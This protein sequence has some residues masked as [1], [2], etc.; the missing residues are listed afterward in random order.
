MIIALAHFAE[1]P[2]ENPYVWSL[3]SALR[4]QGHDVRPLPASALFLLR[5][6]SARAASTI[7]FQWFETQVGADSWIKMALKSVVF[8]AQLG[9]CK[10]LGK[11]LVWTVH[12]ATSHELLF[13]RLEHWVVRRIAA[14]AD[15][16]IF[17]CEAIRKDLSRYLGINDQEKISIVEHGNYFGIYRD[18]ISRDAA[19]SKFRL[20]ESDMVILFLGNIRPYKGLDDLIVAFNDVRRPGIK[21]L[22]AGKPLN[23]SVRQ[24][25]ENLCGNNPDI[26]FRPEFI[27]DDDIQAYLRA[28]DVVA[29][30][31]R[32]ILT[33]GAVILAM[34]FGKA[35]IAPDIGCLSSAISQSA[36][37]LYSPIG[38]EGLRPALEQAIIDKNKLKEMGADNYERAKK[39]DWDRIAA[40]T[41]RLYK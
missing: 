37:Y 27:D 7:H 8:L 28:C 19:R 34:S 4:R 1:A 15:E 22:I 10:L 36:N 2:K 20:A 30:P 21:L 33:S 41:A 12:N 13:P 3:G 17:H 32:Q 5:Y 9:L 26:V 38:L 18:D 16:I 40:E 31:Y 35:C 25:I 24:D 23:D 39:M 14:T 29:F 11:K 6:A